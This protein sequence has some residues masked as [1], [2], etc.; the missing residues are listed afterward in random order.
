MVNLKEVSNFCTMVSHNFGARFN[1]TRTMRGVNV[2]GE[3]YTRTGQHITLMLDVDQNSIK[4]KVYNPQRR[5]IYNDSTKSI[6]SNNALLGF[7]QKTYAS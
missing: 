5:L 4:T 3:F 1:S 2:V 6:M 7:L